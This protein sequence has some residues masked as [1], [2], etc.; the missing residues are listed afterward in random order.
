[1]LY[2]AVGGISWL[3]AGNT[4][5]SGIDRLGKTISESKIATGET[6]RVNRLRGCRCKLMRYQNPGQRQPLRC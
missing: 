3:A 4:S 2:L 6:R 5:D 1:M